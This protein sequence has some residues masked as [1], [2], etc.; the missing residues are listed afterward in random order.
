MIP[1]WTTV[2]V[3][4]DGTPKTYTYKTRF[5]HKVGDR[6]GVSVGGAAKE[7]TVVRIDNEPNLHL[8]KDYVYKWIQECLVP[9]ARVVRYEAGKPPQIVTPEKP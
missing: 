6:V 1:D 3:K 2:G 5:P 4:F 9:V 8:G 7:V